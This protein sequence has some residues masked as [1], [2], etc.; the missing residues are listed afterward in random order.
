M[1]GI[2]GIFKPRGSA[3][4]QT[5]ADVARLMGEAIR[6]RG[7]DD[8][9]VWVNSEQTVALSHQRL[10]IIDLSAHGHQPMHSSSD[11]YTICFN[12]EIYNHLE[13]RQELEGHNHQIQWRGHSDTETLLYCFERW[14]IK[15]TLAKLLGMFAIAVWDKAEHKLSLARDRLGEKPLY[16]G[17]VGSGAE[18]C[19]AFGSELK[20][21]RAL[22]M[23][24]NSVSRPA[25]AQYFRF[26]YIPAPHSIYQDIYKLEPGCL[27]EVD[28]K[29]IKAP[30]EQL[31]YAPHTHD[32]FVLDHWWRLN[33]VVCSS[34]KNKITNIDEA[35]ETLDH[36]LQQAVKSQLISDVPLGAFLS[37]G[38][39]STTVVGMMQ[40][41]STTPVKTFTIA[42]ENPNFDESPFAKQ[43]AQHFGTDHH[44]IFVGAKDIQ[45]VIP[46]VPEIYDEPFADS[47]QLPTYLI[48]KGAR[49]H[50]TVALTGDGGDELFGGY[51]RY[52]LGPRIW[53]NIG[54]IPTP[55]KT[56]LAQGIHAIPTYTL[57][58]LARS[59]FK[60]LPTRLH[61]N[62]VG[63]KAHKL[64]SRLHYVRSSDD[65]YLSLI[66]EW[67]DV[68]DI[69]NSPLTSE[70]IYAGTTEQS[71]LQR[72]APPDTLG[73]QERMMY[74]DALSYL[75]DDILCKV[76]RAAM[77][78]GL[79]TR[80]PFLDHRVIALAWRIPLEM[81]IR[82][83]RGKWLLRRVLDKYIPPS[84][85]DR[86]KSGFAVP[87][88]EWLRGPLM[89]W[90]EDMLDPSQLKKDGFLNV[91][92]VQE[93]WQQHKEGLQDWTARL[94]TI[95]MF[96]SWLRAQPVAP[97]NCR[98]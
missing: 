54:W 27:L 71:L 44:E 79:E 14:G 85:M 86:P 5:L 73:D 19:F 8:A 33:D 9:G 97:A 43:T 4:A 68:A 11:K 2:A 40:R 78:V 28:Q 77:R 39:D 95:L 81:K 60:V 18:E 90:A 38:I 12:G 72:L 16:Y 53:K 70:S 82:D 98:F 87:V 76:D 92:R 26:T 52:L 51:N 24:N 89:S 32:G 42:F 66:S 1:C 36:T 57:D 69:L 35:I 21:L 63:E 15:Q 83:G 10:A 88:G 59:I 58:T 34:Q 20:A 93:L 64:A 45:N 7:P 48:C 13:L 62:R 6:H 67:H 31:I 46:I 49:A 91:A 41:Q 17:W 84:L 37:G 22:P 75:P 23:F 65:L 25:L 96:Q 61:I 55:L 94:W 47:S 50:A 56:T 29:L 30:P 74:W 80:T 3:S